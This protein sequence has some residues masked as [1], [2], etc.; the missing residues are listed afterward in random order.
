MNSPG[1]TARGLDSKAGWEP[2]LNRKSKTRAELSRNIQNRNG[3]EEVTMEQ[4]ALTRREF[5]VSYGRWSR[6]GGY[7][8]AAKAIGPVPPKTKW[9]RRRGQE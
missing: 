7:A 5:L 1:G 3:T 4:R 6:G 2:P 9:T 8:R